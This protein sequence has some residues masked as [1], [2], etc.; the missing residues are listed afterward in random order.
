MAIYSSC[1]QQCFLDDRIN[2]LPDDAHLLA[3]HEHQLYLDGQIAGK[4]IDFST[5]PP[6]LIEPAP[7]SIEELAEVER[8]WRDSQ[9]EETDGVVTRHRDEREEGIATTFT[10]GQYVELQV[11][12]RQLR[13]WPR[14]PE[15]PTQSFRPVRPRWYI[16]AQTGPAGLF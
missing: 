10:E 15:F 12:R 1:S 8:S 9:L 4:V 16:D 11:Y 6:T 2:P 14:S 3:S 5:C 13:D 7:L